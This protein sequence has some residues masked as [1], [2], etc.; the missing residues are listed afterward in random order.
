MRT[1]LRNLG[2]FFMV[3]V[4]ALASSPT[5]GTISSSGRFQLDG[6]E[7][8]NQSS[9]FDGVSVQTQKA[10]SR[11]LLRNGTDLRLGAATQS[12]VYADRM[13]L[14]SGALEGLL[15]SQF[16]V[17][18]G[19]LGLRV[20]GQNARAHIRVQDGEVLVA[21]LQGPVSVRG[22]QGILLASLAEG[23]SVRLS[24]SQGGT[25]GAKLTGVVRQKG[26]SYFL[27]DES[28]NVIAEIRGADV[29]K[30]VGK[31]VTVTGQ[32]D[33]ATK[34]VGDAEYVVR[35]ATFESPVGG[36]STATTGASSTTGAATKG[37]GMSTMAKVGIV[38]GIAVAGGAT[39]G[40]VIANSE[41]KKDTVSA[42]P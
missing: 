20:Q 15:S 40:L 19:T 8:W 41:D 26:S 25:A 9:I 33:L 23:N 2:I 6:A 37:A 27:K 4:L 34:A 28:T 39:T 35:G 14:S 13:I 29:A 36:A 5:I 21:S 38:G 18:T 12:R 11:L 22:A 24:A 7:I 16:R 42:Q 30:H 10:A 1:M 32:V 3:A 17:E 31:R